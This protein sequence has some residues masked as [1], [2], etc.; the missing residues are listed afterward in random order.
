[1]VE[2]RYRNE[3]E[4]VTIMVKVES[5]GCRR[6]GRRGPAGTYPAAWLPS[7][8]NSLVR[9]GRCSGMLRRAL[10]VMW[11]DHALAC[12]NSGKLHLVKVGP[13]P[14]WVHW[15]LN[16]LVQDISSSVVD[17]RCSSWW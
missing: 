17:P 7:W 8:V 13:S 2:S 3:V 16:T 12:H 11:E 14:W 6:R 15:L 1:M 10:R 9:A 5:E 4:D